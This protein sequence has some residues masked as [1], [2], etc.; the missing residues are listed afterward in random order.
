MKL[1]SALHTKLNHRLVNSAGTAQAHH[2]RQLRCRAPELSSRA[3]ASPITPAA[4]HR[5]PRDPRRFAA[6]EGCSSAR[7]VVGASSNASPDGV[8]D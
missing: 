4:E 1:K 3:V 7:R 2:L 8:L 5:R 6:A